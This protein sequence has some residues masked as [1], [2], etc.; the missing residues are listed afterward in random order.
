MFAAPREFPGKN[1]F[2]L[3]RSA[4]RHGGLDHHHDVARQHLPQGMRGVADIADIR[5]AV[6]ALG[7]AHGDEGRV[8][9]VEGFGKGGG[10]V[11]PAFCGVA[12]DNFGEAGFI[13][14]AVARAQTGNLGLVRI[15][16]PHVVS[17]IGK[18]GGGDKPHIAGTDHAYLHELSSVSFLLRGT[19]SGPC[20]GKGIWAKGPEGGPERRTRFPGPGRRGRRA[21]RPQVR[22]RHA[23]HEP[24]A[25]RHK[26]VGR[27]IFFL[28]TMNNGGKTQLSMPVTVRY[29]CLRRAFCRTRGGE[30]SFFRRSHACDLFFSAGRRGKP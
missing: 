12:V 28:T 8:D 9:P 29:R 26:A 2:H 4:H 18:T 15:H 3:R 20:G 25:F 30:R 27:G 1:A 17:R 6:L 21:G 5:A 23:K 13:D 24:A 7:R 16:A 19:D 22:I 10:K 11:Q 14:G